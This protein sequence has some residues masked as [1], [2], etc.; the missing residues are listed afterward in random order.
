MEFIC[1]KLPE[2]LLET[3]DRRAR[4]LE[5]TR[6]EYIRRAI[7]HMNRETNK[8]HVR[9]A[10][11]ARASRKVRRGSMPLNAEFDRIE[12]DSRGRTF[13]E[14]LAS[15]PVEGIDIQRPR[16]KARIIRL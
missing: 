14:L 6:A 2:K 1:I 5:I 12:R 3:S 13:K 15:A 4:A 7:E 8:A 9:A 16:E 10:Q 11:M